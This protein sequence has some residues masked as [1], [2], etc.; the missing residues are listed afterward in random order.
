MLLPLTLQMQVEAIKMAPKEMAG[1]DVYRSN[2]R[3]TINKRRFNIMMED[4]GVK[5]ANYVWGEG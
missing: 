3:I 1:E 2:R 4:T 5:L